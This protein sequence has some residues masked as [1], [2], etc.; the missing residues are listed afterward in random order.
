MK[1]KI[2]SVLLCVMLILPFAVCAVADSDAAFENIGTITE[3]IT[4]A[5]L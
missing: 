4:I 1:K 5:V 2:L 3:E